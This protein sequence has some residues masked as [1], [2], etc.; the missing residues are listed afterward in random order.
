VKI[1]NTKKHSAYK[2]QLITE[3]EKYQLIL[4]LTANSELVL[5]ASITA[6][7]NGKCINY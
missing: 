7:N 2:I 4:H 5:Q 1:T 3:T 6:Y